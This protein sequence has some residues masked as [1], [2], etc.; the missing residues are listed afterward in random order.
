MDSYAHGIEYIYT[1]NVRTI[2]PEVAFRFIN[3]HGHSHFL[4][5]PV[6]VY[7]SIYSSQL[8]VSIFT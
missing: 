6:L 4:I 2:C 3:L 5:P 1:S 8:V 7:Y